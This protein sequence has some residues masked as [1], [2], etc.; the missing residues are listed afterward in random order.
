MTVTPVASVGVPTTPSMSCT[1]V[2]VDGSGAPLACSTVKGTTW[3]VI[4]MAPA[5]GRPDALSDPCELSSYSVAPWLVRVSFVHEAPK[6]A[7][8][9]EP[10]KGW[11]AGGAGAL[12]SPQPATAAAIAIPARSA[13]CIS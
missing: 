10:V 1:C 8:N 5:A 4:P 3:T 2:S 13:R 9:P 6:R 12:A 11:V 7:V